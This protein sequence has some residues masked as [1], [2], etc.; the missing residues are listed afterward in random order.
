MNV[1]TPLPQQHS[2]ERYCLHLCKLVPEA[3]SWTIREAEETFESG[4]RRA[5]RH[6][7]G[8][9]RFVSWQISCTACRCP[10]TGVKSFRICKIVWVEA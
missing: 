9:S 2:Q 3:R 7:V 6:F 8:L 5:A 4:E 1:Y 10:A